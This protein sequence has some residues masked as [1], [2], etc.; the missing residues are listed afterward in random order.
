MPNIYERLMIGS[1]D[2]LYPEQ[3][4]IPQV[5]AFGIWLKQRLDTFH[6]DL[7]LLDLQYPN[8]L[9]LL[10]TCYAYARHQ[11]YEG[12]EIESNA[13]AKFYFGNCYFLQRED[14]EG[15][16][17][18]IFFPRYFFRSLRMTFREVTKHFWQ[19]SH[20]DKAPLTTIQLC[21]AAYYTHPV[22]EA[23]P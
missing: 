17:Y 21:L 11:A 22:I 10:Q 3:G 14:A 2:R 9:H 15:Y 18:A 4:L 13:W 8:P 1:I 19:V 16:F 5:S 6:F 7:R 12:L 23:A 20:G